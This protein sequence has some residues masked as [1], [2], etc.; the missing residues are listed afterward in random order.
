MAATPAFNY[1]SK[2]A[3][4]FVLSAEDLAAG[5]KMFPGQVRT[6]M[7]ASNALVTAL[8][9]MERAILRFVPRRTAE[10]R[11]KGEFARSRHL[12]QSIKREAEIWGPRGGLA[13]VTVTAPHAHLLEFGHEHYGWTY[14]NPKTGK[15][16]R[17][18]RDATRRRASF[19]GAKSEK[20]TRPFSDPREGYIR[21]AFSTTKE[22]CAARITDALG[23]AVEK[24]WG[25]K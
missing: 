20:K 24:A 16:S 8:E 15:Y 25:V 1:R 13:A 11:A 19:R 22:E 7:K 5:L 14:R 23:T 12:Y 17:K 2:R 18:W 3:V 10:Q 9:P 4:N 21:K 6:E